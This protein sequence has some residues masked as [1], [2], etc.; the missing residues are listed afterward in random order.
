V[1]RLIVGFELLVV[2]SESPSEK[3]D[4]QIYKGVRASA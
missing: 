2:G 3:R 4:D 1:G